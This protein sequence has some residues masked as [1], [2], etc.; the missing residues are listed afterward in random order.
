MLLASN[1]AYL[2]EE[3]SRVANA[4]KA[5]LRLRAPKALDQVV[6][7]D[8]GR[9]AREDALAALHALKDR[10]HHCC[11]LAGACTATCRVSDHT[12][13]HYLTSGCAVLLP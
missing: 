5:H 13:S 9:G 2:R 10:L 11:C 4:H 3:A 7:S 8:V 1:V 12:P 6:Y